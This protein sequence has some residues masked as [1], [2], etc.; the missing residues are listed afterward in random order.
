MD[1]IENT[2]TQAVE[3]ETGTLENYKKEIYNKLYYWCNSNWCSC[4]HY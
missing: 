4:W 2:D 3:K 1:Y